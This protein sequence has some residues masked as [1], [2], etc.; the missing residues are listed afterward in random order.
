MN[1]E[2]LQENLYEYL[3]DSLPPSRKSAVEKHL[4]ECSACREA[5][6]QEQELARSLSGRFEQSVQSVSLDLHT[7]C[8]IMAAVEKKFSATPRR[9]PIPF[10]KRWA[11]P[12]AATAVVLA[13]GVWVGHNFLSNP[14][15]TTRLPIHAAEQ[16]VVVHVSYSTPHYIF[17]RDGNTVVDTLINDPQDADG[18]LFVAN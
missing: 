1:C 14:P 9:A 18:T 8:R 4:A 15:P 16:M 7:Q 5:V 2:D 11:L 17:R 12:L 6:R 10:W 13:C 3:E